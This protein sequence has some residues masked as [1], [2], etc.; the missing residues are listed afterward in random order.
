MELKVPM[1][2]L[3][4]T[5]Q[6]SNY[7]GSSQCKRVQRVTKEARGFHCGSSGEVRGLLQPSC[8]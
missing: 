4:R 6:H 2:H 8:I 7:L 5:L 3:A 1:S